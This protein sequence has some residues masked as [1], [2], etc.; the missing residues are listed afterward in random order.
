MNA[1]APFDQ[2]TRSAFG[3]EP[4]GAIGARLKAMATQVA[5]QK[6]QSAPAD[7]ATDQVVFLASG[8]TKL[9][10]HASLER[11][12]IVA[13]HFGGDIIAIPSDSFYIYQLTALVDAE[14]LVFPAREFF[15][16]AASHSSIARSLLGRLTASLYRCRDKAVALGQKSASERLAGFL[17]GMSER[18]GKPYRGGCLLDLPMSRRDI[19]DSLGLTIETVSRQIGLLRDAGLVETQGRS[20]IRLLD[21][22]ALLAMSG[23]LQPA[24]KSTDN[25]SNLISINA[26]VAATG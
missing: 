11:E 4:G 3:L 1:A 14:L 22:D 9:S 25:D 21:L 2:F 13:F 18:V 6:G 16:L 17:L 8:A 23:H 26:R 12:Q 19:G 7:Q 20:R 15:D 24:K 10:A 5:L